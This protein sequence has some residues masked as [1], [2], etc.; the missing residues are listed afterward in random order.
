[1][2]YT[3]VKEVKTEL[4][5]SNVTSDRVVDLLE[6][7]ILLLEEIKKYLKKIYNPE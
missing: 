4:E 1:M 3:P 2:S 6:K 5:E 7:Q